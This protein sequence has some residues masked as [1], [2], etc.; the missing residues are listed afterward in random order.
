MTPSAMTQDA[1]GANVELVAPDTVAPGQTVPLVFR[2][3]DAQTGQPLTDLVDSHERPMHL[4]AVRQDLE[5]FQH[6]HPQPTGTPGEYR[7]EATFPEPGTYLLFDEFTRAS[8][9]QVVHRDTLTVGA[10]S[11]SAAVLTEDLS[12]KLDGQTR[13][14]LQSAA[15]PRAGQ[16]ARPTFRIE[17][18]QTGQPVR[19]LSP[20]LGAPA[21]A[22]ILD[23]AAS[24]FVHTHGEA[25]GATDTGHMAADHGAGHGVGQGNVTY[26]PEIAIEHTFPAPGLYKLWGQFQTRDGQVVTADFVVRVDE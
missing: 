15:P 17:N 8:G 25:V 19:D 11:A 9:Q 10:P 14:R 4:I 13:V 3:T 12:P 1:T 18:A 6:I 2:L 23:Q 22:V 26:G 7:V 5:Q 24:T 20:Y 21:H 16:P